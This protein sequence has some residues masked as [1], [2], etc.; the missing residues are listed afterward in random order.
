VR[1]LAS[2]AGASGAENGADFSC[3]GTLSRWRTLVQSANPS[4]SRAL[5]GAL[6][7]FRPEIVHVRMFLTQL[8]PLI[9]PLL[10]PV[11]SLYHVVWYRAVCPLGTKL[12]PDGSVCRS[13]WGR[14]CLDGGCLPLHDW[15]PLMAQ[16]RLWRRWRDAFDAVVANSES[17]HARLLEDGFTDVETIPNGV[18]HRAA[19][20]PL[21][22]PPVAVFAGR[23]VREKGARV[24]LEAFARAGLTDA[25]LILAGEGPERPGLERRLAELGLAG[26]VELTG[27]LTRAELERRFESAW[28]QAAPGLWE[29]PFGNAVAEAMMRGSAVVVS[30][31]G[32]ASDHVLEGVTG[33]R[34]PPGDVD[35]LAAALR[36]LL[37]DRALAERMGKAG[38]ER[39]LARFSEETWLAR[40][41]EL[42]GRLA[43]GGARRSG[44]P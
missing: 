44:R 18:P 1:L 27:Q 43:A 19:R 2:T 14:V 7:T 36:G 16:M 17:V 22:G 35:R 3:F 41:E 4:A 26:R 10:R 40:F 6:A 37:S 8:S 21:E 23:L 31:G 30:D 24:L 13:P 33:F 12:L 29:E 34:V 15:L 42:Y 28:V 5:A 38:R 9:L 32:G 11:P 25:R 20:P 39:A